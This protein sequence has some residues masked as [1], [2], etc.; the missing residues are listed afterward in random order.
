MLCLTL[1]IHFIL[2][3]SSKVFF[4]QITK[5]IQLG[6]SVI[7]KCKFT[8]NTIYNTEDVIYMYKNNLLIFDFERSTNK[9]EFEIDKNNFASVKINRVTTEDLNSVYKCSYNNN[10]S[11]NYKIKINKNTFTYTP[12]KNDILVNHSNS[13]INL[14]FVKIYP[15][16]KCYLI[17]DDDIKLFNIK[18]K[19]I[20]SKFYY[21]INLY[22]KIDLIQNCDETIR[23]EC[24][25]GRAHV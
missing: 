19:N 13:I 12:I 16:P 4:V 20:L 7:L 2:G 9:Y 10:T 25:I 24:E 15:I 3:V 14:E 8:N 22:F 11:K 18:N 5:N 6:G 1:I 17:I 21:N 23:I